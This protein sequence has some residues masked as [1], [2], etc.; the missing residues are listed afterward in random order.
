TLHVWNAFQIDGFRFDCTE[1]I[2]N[3]QQPN[4]FIIARNPDGSWCTGSGGGWQFLG[5]LRTAL[6]QAA[7]AAG[8]PWPYLVGENDPNNWGMTDPRVP[9]VLDGQWGFTELYP[10]GDMARHDGSDVASAIASAMEF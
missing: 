1:A 10:L 3:G 5:S 2:I 8:R 9:G 4:E 7:N 6:R